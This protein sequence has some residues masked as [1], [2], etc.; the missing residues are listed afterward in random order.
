MF[1]KLYK[2]SIIIIASAIVIFV[3]FWAFEPNN[4]TAQNNDT[5]VV[6]SQIK[7][8]NSNIMVLSA[9]LNVMKEEFKKA[10]NP[11]D[12]S[13]KGISGRLNALSQDV[14]AINSITNKLQAD[15]MGFQ[16]DLRVMVLK[17]R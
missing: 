15:V 10:S 4:L 7:Q 17:N 9:D 13:T 1:E 16:E 2:I 14:R 12:L 3:I 5:E 6:Q 11:G 8:L